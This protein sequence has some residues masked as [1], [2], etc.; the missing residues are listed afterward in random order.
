MSLLAEKYTRVASMKPCGKISRN[1]QQSLQVVNH[2]WESD[3][4][5]L[6]RDFRSDPCE[7]LPRAE[8]SE[9][10]ESQG[11]T[12]YEL[13]KKRI[14][15]VRSS[16]AAGTQQET[17]KLAET[18]PGVEE[19]GT[20]NTG[21]IFMKMTMVVGACRSVKPAAS[22]K[23]RRDPKST[24]V[25]AKTHPNNPMIHSPRWQLLWKYSSVCL[26]IDQRPPEGPTQIALLYFVAD[27]P[28]CAH[29]WRNL[30]WAPPPPRPGSG[31]CSSCSR[32]PCRH[33]ECDP[34][35][36]TLQHRLQHKFTIE[37]VEI[38]ELLKR[39]TMIRSRLWALLLGLCVTSAI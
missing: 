23:W 4:A 2:A 12:W 33:L 29:G 20:K 39:K 6:T 27:A 7:K 24:Q 1:F 17:N 16:C 5:W 31:A 25:P 19:H 38:W 3:S 15:H 13:L 37:S 30:E 14:P 18:R 26:G 9:G 22:A 28:F 34:E 10:G 36:K 21:K 32:F 8:N 35:L 11:Y